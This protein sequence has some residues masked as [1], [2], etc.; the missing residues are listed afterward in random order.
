MAT[1]HA[2][3]FLDA[4]LLLSSGVG[5]ADGFRPE[6][7]RVYKAYLLNMD[8]AKSLLRLPGLVEDIAAIEAR[9][10]AE[11]ESKRRSVKSQEE[12]DAVEKEANAAELAAVKSHLSGDFIPS[13][14][15]GITALGLENLSKEIPELRAPLE[16]TLQSV[17]I[18]AW[19]AFEVLAKQLWGEAQRQSKSS[20]VS[21]TERE[22][23]SKNFGFR[24]R[25]GIR[26]T[27]SH[28]F[29]FDPKIDG[30]LD[31]ENIDPLA[32]LRN[33]LVHN[34]GNVDKHF[35]AGT[36]LAALTRF[37]ALDCDD[38]IEIDGPLLNVTINLVT[39]A[40]FDLC[41]GVDDWLENH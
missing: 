16:A 10:F 32:L 27:Y 17:L 38:P 25:S 19:L 6:V 31:K 40:V 37:A 24:S 7:A 34:G 8:R 23:A 15:A 18:Q 5:D 12:H 11:F 29:S 30:A 39:G 22:L 26:S 3:R 9:V 2:L 36:N 13:V 28:S 41:A 4:T 14:G 35:K 1:L 33:A 21:L 20:F